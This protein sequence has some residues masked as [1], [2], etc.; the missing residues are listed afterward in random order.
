LIQKV[1][2]L[3]YLVELELVKLFWFKN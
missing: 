2:K 3:D 1:V